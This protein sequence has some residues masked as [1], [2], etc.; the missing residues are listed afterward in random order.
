M[1]NQS[2]NDGVVVVT[3]AFFS[4][5]V[6]SHVSLNK[7]KTL[8]EQNESL[9]DGNYAQ[10]VYYYFLYGHFFVLCLSNMIFAHNK[11][12]FVQTKG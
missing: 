9:I 5:L 1:Q 2:S 12:A 7:P 4:A 6:T 3:K 11:A 8:Q 10:S